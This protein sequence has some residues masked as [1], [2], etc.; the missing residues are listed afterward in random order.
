[1]RGPGGTKAR[2]HLTEPN[3]PARTHPRSRA[4][5]QVE[6][7]EPPTTPVNKSDSRFEPTST[8]GSRMTTQRRK[9]VADGGGLERTHVSR[10]HPP[11]FDLSPVLTWAGLVSGA[12]VSAPGSMAVYGHRRRLAGP[13]A[14]QKPRLAKIAR[15]VG[16]RRASSLTCSARRPAPISGAARRPAWLYGW[17]Y[18]KA[19]DHLNNRCRGRRPEASGGATGGPPARRVRRASRLV[20]GGCRGWA[21]PAASTTRPDPDRPATPC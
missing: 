5:E 6:E 3:P 13:D 9:L 10:P 19:C 8:S 16:G 17:L 20:H 14:G 4:A 2:L 18:S 12:Y 15:A 7:F 21:S 11:V 1:M